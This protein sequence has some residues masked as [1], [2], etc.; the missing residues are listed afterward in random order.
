MNNVTWCILLVVM[1]V[2][3]LDAI[4]VNVKT[5][6]LHGDL[7]EET[8]MN[9]LDGMEGLDDECLLLLKVL[10]RLVQG[11]HH[12]E[13][14]VHSNP[15][16]HRAFGRSLMIK[17]S[18]NRTVFASVCLL[19]CTLTTTS[20]LETAKH[21]RYLWRTS[22]IRLHCGGVR[23]ETDRLPVLLNQVLQGQDKHMG[24]T[25]SSHHKIERQVCS[26]GQQNAELS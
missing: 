13:E 16:E 21:T 23:W 17:H 11:A 3:N 12:L 26:Y 5:A 9:L 2:W 15:Q 24:W 6:F 7:E 4:I 10:Y 20:V 22:K 14:E 8:Y 18:N 19:L 25:T 1:I